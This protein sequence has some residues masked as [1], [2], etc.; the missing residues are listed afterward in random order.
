MRTRE[1]L[2]WGIWRRWVIANGWSELVGLGGSAGLALLIF[3]IGE[4]TGAAAIVLAALGMIVIATVLEGGVVG[5]AQWLVLRRALPRITGPAWIGVTAL[6]A[7]VAWVLG[8]LPATAMAL[9][10]TPMEAGPELGAAAVIGLAFG[11]GLVLGPVLAFFQW[12]VLR[13]HLPRAG[14]WMPANAVAWAVGMMVVFA[15]AGS[16]P[17][18]ASPV[19]IAAV[20]ATTCLL[21]GAVVGAIHGLVL[22]RLL[23]L[24][25]AAAAPDVAVEPPV[26]ARP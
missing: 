14:W 19:A 25:D 2:D 15:G 20:L 10:E 11:L 4:P 21:A 9:R 8:M 17:E 16:V 24:R 1:P 26:T 7:F 6:G 22:I 18:T 5:A 12:L 3:G 23:R 13:R